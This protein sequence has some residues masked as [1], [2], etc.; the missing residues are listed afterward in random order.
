MQIRVVPAGTYSLVLGEDILAMNTAKIYLQCQTNDGAI[1]I[2]LPKITDGYSS[3]R[4]WWFNIFI[5][6]IDG[7]AATNN[8]TITPHPDD[9]I[10]GSTS[11]VVLNT[12]GVAGTLQVIGD[13]S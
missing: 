1:N 8:I 12:N 3:L 11:Q 5:N 10:N 7:N 6:D 4:N 9:T 13:I 2:L